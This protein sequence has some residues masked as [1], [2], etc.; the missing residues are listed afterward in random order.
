MRA[1]ILGADASLS[2]TWDINA[3]LCYPK[4]Q[5]INDTTVQI[6]T[7]GIGFGKSYWNFMSEKYSYVDAAAEAGY[8]TFS[9]SMREVM[10][11]K[12]GIPNQDPVR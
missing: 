10:M 1:V 4:G 2:G 8:A 9:V 12:Y 7:H 6:L 11:T 5:S 3:M